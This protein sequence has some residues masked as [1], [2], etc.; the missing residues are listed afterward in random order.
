MIRRPPRSTQSRSSAA[1]DVYKRQIGSGLRHVPELEN[2]RWSVVRTHYRSHRSPLRAF[3]VGLV[4]PTHVLGTSCGG[5]ALRSVYLLA[6]SSI[7]LF[8]GNPGEHYATETTTCPFLCPSSTYLWA[9]T[10]CSSGSC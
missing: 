3:A 5:A 6:V 2:I 10:I 1:S 7:P 4:R 8:D 9:S